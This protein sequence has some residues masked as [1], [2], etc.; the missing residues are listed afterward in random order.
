MVTSIIDLARNLGLTCVAE[1]VETREQLE[2]LEQKHCPE[3]QGY[4][5]SPAVPAQACG[6]LMRAG[7]AHSDVTMSFVPV[8]VYNGTPKGHLSHV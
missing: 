6:D 4:L 5:Y 7:T 3:I 8:S 1:G 2:Y